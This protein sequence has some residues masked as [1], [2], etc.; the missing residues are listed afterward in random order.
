MDFLQWLQEQQGQPTVV[1]DLAQDSLRVDAP[2]SIE[3]FRRHLQAYQ[4][5]QQVLDAFEMAAVEYRQC[6]PPAPIVSWSELCDLYDQLGEAAQVAMAER[7][8]KDAAELMGVGNMLYDSM[9]HHLRSQSRC[10]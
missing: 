3:E 7:R 5:P 8:L 4:A 10:Q 1:G 9:V 2:S 6:T